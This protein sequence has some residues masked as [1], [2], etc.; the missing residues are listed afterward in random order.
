MLSGRVCRCCQGVFAAVVRACLRL[1]KDEHSDVAA[2]TDLIE[3][4]ALL[5][6]FGVKI[7][8][9]QV[10]MSADRAEMI[11]MALQAKVHTYKNSQR[12]SSLYSVGIQVLQRSL[13][14]CIL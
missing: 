2:E 1:I 10:R 12:V 6:G 14:L 8:P 5:D 7:L 4:L 9:L 11:Q 13:Y 3:A